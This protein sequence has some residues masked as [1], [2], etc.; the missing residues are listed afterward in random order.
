MDVPTIP[1]KTGG[2]SHGHPGQHAEAKDQL[3][4]EERT[5]SVTTDQFSVLWLGVTDRL[6]KGK[7]ENQ[8]S[9]KLLSPERN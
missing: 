4:A 8:G 3:V 9:H 6:W 2:I 5:A 1:G 7:L